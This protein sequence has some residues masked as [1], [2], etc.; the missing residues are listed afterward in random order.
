MSNVT[1][2]VA[3]RES[4]MAKTSFAP[5]ASCTSASAMES[6]GGPC[7]VAV[8]AFDSALPSG[9]QSAPAASQPPVVAGSVTVTAPGPS[10]AP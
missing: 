2:P 8:G 7:T 5:G 3:A 4:V 9:V 10:A 1:V 6:P